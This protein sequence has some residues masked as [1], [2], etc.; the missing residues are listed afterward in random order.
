MLQ[1]ADKRHLDTK[2]NRNL[3]D[4][5]TDELN[6]MIADLLRK[7]GGQVSSRGNLKYDKM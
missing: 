2:V 3:F 1:K 7:L 4:S 6:K 5:T